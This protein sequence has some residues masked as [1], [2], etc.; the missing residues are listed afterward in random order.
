MLWF[1][2]LVANSSRNVLVMSLRVVEK[3]VTL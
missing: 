2:I 1:C 3:S